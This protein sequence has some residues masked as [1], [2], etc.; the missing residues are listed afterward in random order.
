MI[1]M[2][3]LLWFSKKENKFLQELTWSSL[4]RIGICLHI[5]RA[6]IILAENLR[7]SSAYSFVWIVDMVSAAKPLHKNA[8]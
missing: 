4:L 1:V 2:M 7:R 5:F 6:E 3:H 8:G